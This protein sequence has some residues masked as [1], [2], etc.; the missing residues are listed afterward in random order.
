MVKTGQWKVTA[1][2]LF[3][4]LTLSGTGAYIAG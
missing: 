2:T 4:L 3:F 1:Q